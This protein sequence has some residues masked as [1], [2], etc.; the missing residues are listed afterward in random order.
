MTCPHLNFNAVINCNRLTK[1]EDDPIV[2][3]YNA[4]IRIN[5]YDCGLP[6]EFI[7][8]DAG[9]MPDKPMASVDA[10]ELRAP[11]RPKGCKLLPAV[12]GFTVRAN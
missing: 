10:Q 11:I 8:V 3:A 7:G 2:V 6:F 12:P 4:E 9:M 1:G 5:C